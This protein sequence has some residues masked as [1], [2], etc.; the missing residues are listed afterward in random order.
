MTLD[1]FDLIINLVALGMGVFPSAPSRF[2]A[3]SETCVASLGLHVS[4]GNWSSLCGAIVK[5]PNMSASL[6]RTYYF[7]IRVGGE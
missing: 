2:M 5:S 1:N 4:P 6:S 3:E 7:R